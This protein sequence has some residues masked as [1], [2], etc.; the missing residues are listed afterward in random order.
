MGRPRASLGRGGL[1]PP[2]L[3]PRSRRV[4]ALIPL[5][6]ALLVAQLSGDPSAHPREGTRLLA[7]VAITAGGWLIL[8]ETASRILVWRGARRWLAR[9]EHLAQGLM[10]GL[11]GWIC[12][13]HGWTDWAPGLTAA[14]AP[15]LFMQLALWWSMAPA[16]NRLGGGSWTRGGLVLHHLR[17]E[18]LP[19]VI[20]LPAIDLCELA[21][22]HLSI[23]SWFAGPDGLLLQLI[24]GWLLVTGFLA[25]LPALIV[26]LWGGR[27]L[28][29][30]PLARQLHEDCARAGLP[31]VRVRVWD[32]PGGSVHNAVAL[33]IVPGLRWVMVSRDLLADLP[34]GEVRAVVG[35]ELGHHRHGHLS[36]Y[37]WFALAAN[38]AG[39]AVMSALIGTVDAG[40]HPLKLQFGFG[41]EGGQGLLFAIPGIAAIPPDAVVGAAGLL[42]ALFAW[43]VVFG[44]LSRACERE[45]D[46]HGAQVAGGDDMASALQRVARSSG[47]PED[48]PSWRHR[49]IAAR[50]AFL[51]LLAQHPTLA[52]THRKTVRD[53]RLIIIASLALLVTVGASMWFDPRREVGG[54]KDPAGAVRTW[55]EHDP[56]LAD[57]LASADKGDRSPLI[58]WL[59]R[60][61]QPAR[62]RLALLHLKMVEPASTEGMDAHLPP[63]DRLMWRLRDRFAALST[64]SFDDPRISLG[65]DNVL[66]YGLV[67]GTAAPLPRD[68]ELARSI[69]PRLEAAM[70]AEPLHAVWDTIG[71]V[72]FAS[73]DFD[74][75]RRAFEDAGRLLDKDQGVPAEERVLSAKLYRDRKDAATANHQQADAAHPGPR[76]NLPLTFS[77]NAA[78]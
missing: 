14:V 59:N 52:A 74:G 56:A 1:A 37:L 29:D 75:A 28:E 4:G 5:L 9:W 45:A 6:L 32:S 43:R 73:G 11:F 15:W 63:D 23:M 61:E 46:I 24:G 27:P 62:M 76:R 53:M 33:G 12:Y 38:L 31:D 55:G 22:R 42:V 8:A 51:R 64:S 16:A 21:G 47:T 35:H 34:P 78:P 36:T 44:S 30:G 48:A 65:V 10:L 40:H 7:T 25:V 20:A 17:F 69:L 13:G 77:E 57:A 26:P 54:I 49:P 39:W 2:A 3:A 60:A 67:A 50:L 72:R 18:L 58:S 41:T 19:V 66:A 71:C 68:I 70:S